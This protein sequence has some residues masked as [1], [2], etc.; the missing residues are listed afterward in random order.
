MLNISTPCQ[1]VLS[2][3]ILQTDTSRFYQASE[4]FRLRAATSKQPV[5]P[6]HFFCSFERVCQP[7]QIILL[8]QLPATG[9][10]ACEA[11]LLWLPE[12]APVLATIRYPGPSVL[13]KRG[14]EPASQEQIFLGFGMDLAVTFCQ[15]KCDHG[16]PCQM[17][18]FFCQ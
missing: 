7:E 10:Q 18:G 12:S 11:S 17:P 6:V 14:G 5:Y 2:D 8:Q 1:Q 4:G 15:L 13:F 9:N 16:A 3:S